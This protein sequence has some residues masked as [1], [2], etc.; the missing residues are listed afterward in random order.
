MRHGNDTLSKT[1]HIS[2]SQ[3]KLELQ[4]V[5]LGKYDHRNY[6]VKLICRVSI[7]C[8]IDVNRK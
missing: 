4:Y 3:E 1:F 8:I 2:P 5:V 7:V 6:L